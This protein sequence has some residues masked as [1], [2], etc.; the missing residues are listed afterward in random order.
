MD[1]LWELTYYAVFVA[2]AVL[3]APTKN[4]Q[5]Y[6]YSIELS[7]MD[8]EELQASSADQDAG[9]SYLDNEYGGR[10]DDSSDPFRGKGTAVALS[11]N[12]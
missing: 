5:R 3:W 6:S 7:Q 10:L 2:M 12:N 11:K 8:E 1:A 4:S 9:D